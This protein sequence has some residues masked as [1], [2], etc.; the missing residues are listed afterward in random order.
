MRAIVALI[1]CT[2]VLAGNAFAQGN[3]KVQIHFI[4]VGQGDGCARCVVHHSARSHGAVRR[5][6]PQFL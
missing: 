2:L 5:R 3:R 4:N 6:R 1:A